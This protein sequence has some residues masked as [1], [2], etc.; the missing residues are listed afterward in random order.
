MNNMNNLINGPINI[1]RLVGEINDTP[2][3]LYIMMDVHTDKTNCNDTRSI[4]VDKFISEEFKKLANLPVKKGETIPTYDLFLEIEPNEL[5]MKKM[6]KSSPTT[7]IGKVNRVGQRIKLEKT[8]NI[9]VHAIDIRAYNDRLD[10]IIE[11]IIKRIDEKGEELDD[12]TISYI[13]DELEEIVKFTTILKSIFPQEGGQRAGFNDISALTTILTKIRDRYNLLDI[14]TKMRSILAETLYKDIQIIDSIV[15]DVRD[16]LKIQTDDITFRKSIRQYTYS[17]LY[18]RLRSAFMLF[19]FDAMDLYFIRRFIDK[20]YIT[21]GMVYVGASHACNFIYLLVKYF[22]F[23]MT[24]ISNP[25]MT[26][27]EIDYLNNEIKRKDNAEEI[28]ELLIPKDQ[29]QCSDIS[30]FPPF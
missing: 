21:N 14:K 26:D 9:R 19:F 22:N 23:K 15:K 11:K 5:N 16:K 10:V 30:G 13:N 2:K 3:I 12:Y 24:H 25:K 20:E 6:L 28:E 17:M 8:N 4:D 1:I 18:I 27:L 29:I 7:Y